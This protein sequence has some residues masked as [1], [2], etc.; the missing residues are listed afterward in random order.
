MLKK[1]F[2]ATLLVLLAVKPAFADSWNISVD[3][4]ALAGQTGWLD[5]QF[6]PAD[7][8]A[9]AST[10]SVTAFNSNGSLLSAASATGDVAGSLASALIFGNSQYLNDQ[11]QSFIFGTTMRFS[12][13]IN[14]PVSSVSGSGTAF[15]LSVYDSNFSSLLADPLWGAALVINADSSGTMD[16]LAQSG[17]VSVSAVPEP[18]EFSLMLAG[19]CLSGFISWRRKQ[20]KV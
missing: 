9:P 12:V 7:S 18:G 4:G 14:S 5:F 13:N 10:A 8:S 11:L 16:V 19:F 17:A 6:N 20:Q 3:T 1:V 2:V 15:S